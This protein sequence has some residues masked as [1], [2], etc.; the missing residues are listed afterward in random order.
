M[1]MRLDFLAQSSWDI[2]CPFIH[3]MEEATRIS[4]KT[5]H[6]SNNKPYLD[7]PNYY[8]TT[9]ILCIIFHKLKSGVVAL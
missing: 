6:F 9:D 7:T 8:A 2:S 5:F 1:N 3:G 4:V